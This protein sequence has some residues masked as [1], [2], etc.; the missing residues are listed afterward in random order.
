MIKTELIDVTK[1]SKSTID[2]IR[3]LEIIFLNSIYNYFNCNVKD[4]FKFG[5]EEGGKSY[6][7]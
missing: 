3:K 1:I 2:K 4:V 7:K 6:G 5:A